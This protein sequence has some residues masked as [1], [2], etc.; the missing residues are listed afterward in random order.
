MHEPYK[1]RSV[2]AAPVYELNRLTQPDGVFASAFK[3]TQREHDVVGCKYRLHGWSGDQRLYYG[4]DGR[5]DPWMYD[6]QSGEKP[7]RTQRLPVDPGI[8]STVS[9]A[10]IRP[11]GKDGLWVSRVVEESTSA[12]SMITA[13]VIQDSFYGPYDVIVLRRTGSE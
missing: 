9:T 11:T 6:P 8:S 5:N 7:H 10:D 13:Y 12:D 1:L 4:S 3:S 2:S